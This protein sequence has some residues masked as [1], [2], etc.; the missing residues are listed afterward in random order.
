MGISDNPKK[1]GSGPTNRPSTLSH[2]HPG[3]AYFQPS[4]KIH[5]L[6]KDQLKP[7]VEP[8][9][10]LITALQEGVAKR[11]DVFIAQM[12]LKDLEKDY[13]KDLLTDTTDALIWLDNINATHNPNIKKSYKSYTFDYKALYDSLKPDLV[14]E[15]LQE[16]MS[17]CR[18]DWTPEFSAWIVD[19]VNLSL[20]A[21]VGIFEGTW[22]RQKNGV[23]TGG[24]L[25]VQLANIAVYRI[26][27]KVIYSDQQLMKK[28]AALKRYIDDGSGVFIGTK[29][30]FSEWIRTVNTR[31]AAY[32]LNIDEWTIEDP[33]EP[34]AFLD[35]EF[36]FDH[37]GVLQTDLHVKETDARSYLNFG[38]CHPNHVYSGTVYS[39]CLRLRRIINSQPRLLLR[40]EE[41]KTCFVSAGYPK[42]MVDNISKK[43]ATMERT[44]SRRTLDNTNQDTDAEN[45]IRIVSTYGSDKDLVATVK[46]Y[47]PHLQKTTSFGDLR[48][49]NTTKKKVFQYVKKTGANIRNRLVKVKYLALGNKFGQTE[50]CNNRNC[51]GCELISDNLSF[52]INNVT[53]KTAPGTCST[54]NVI[55]L[56]VCKH[57]Y[58]A[59][60]GRTIQELK[61]RIGQHRRAYYAV[62]EN[63]MNCEKF[64]D[65]YSMGLH[66]K[67]V[68]N[69]NNRSDFNDSFRFV[70]LENCSPRAIEKRE[71]YFIHKLN[72][73]RPNGINTINPFS[74][75]VLV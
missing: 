15:A 10:R 22:Y 61:E 1:D 32:G 12:F 38:S 39:Q 73:L 27:N 42:T 24:S 46:K 21:S 19:L 20:Q 51:G 71:H 35:I 5:K 69:F 68:H 3:K 62:I 47:E 29:R 74:I 54:Y 45:I 52:C 64:D 11:S 16:A 33:N 34:V 48:D 43:V 40:L 8:P 41:L 58:M 53:V 17:E 7:G 44:L 55:Y 25:C 49:P 63:K 36:C 30:Q 59:Y 4:M 13:C 72:T 9:I 56:A 6:P 23:P 50:P 18:P 28:I 67:D 2:Y 57:C 26:M 65:T 14:V 75:P 70:I 66:L 31:L 60:V 37:Q